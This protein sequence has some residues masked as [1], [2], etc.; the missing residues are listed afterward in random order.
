MDHHVPEQPARGAD[1]TDGRRGRIARRDGNKF[2][3]ADFAVAK[4]LFEMC[5]M[6]IKPA[7]E[8]R[9]EG[10]PGGLDRVLAG[11]GAVG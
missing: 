1:V 4:P 10:H 11:A 9:E 8:G 5:E 7:V 2:D 6:R 3:V